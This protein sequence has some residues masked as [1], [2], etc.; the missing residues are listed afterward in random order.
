MHTKDPC[1]PVQKIRVGPHNYPQMPAQNNFKTYWKKL[2]FCVMYCIN[3][4]FEL[5]N[6]TGKKLYTVLCKKYEI[7]RSTI[8]DIN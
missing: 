2:S 3:Q 4:K 8:T 1:P 7:G 6:Q 5:L